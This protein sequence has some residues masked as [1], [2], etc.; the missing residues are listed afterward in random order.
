[1]TNIGSYTK[2]VL[3]NFRS[4]KNFG[5]I[6]NPSGVG[7]VGNIVCGDVMYL[8][9]KVNKKEIIEDIKYETYG[10]VAAI[11]TSNMI[12]KLAKNKTI[13]EALKISKQDIVD[14]LKGL[15]KIKVHCSI[16]AIDALTEAVF[17]Y[18]KKNNIKISEELMK[19]HE[20]LKKEKDE[21]QDRY[22]DWISLQKK[23]LKK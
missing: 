14:S 16:L 7:E 8:Y 19:K 15:P 4:P 2:E 12:C 11:A 22:K 13:K 20:H 3:E 6:K 1:M 5:K 23:S 10:C 18:Y 9:I 21:I 17:D